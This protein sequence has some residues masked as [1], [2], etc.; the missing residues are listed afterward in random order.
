MTERNGDWVR[1]TVSLI[2]NVV[3]VIIAVAV[4]YGKLVGLQEQYVNRAEA[5]D[6]FISRNELTAQLEAINAKQSAMQKQL[7]RIEQKL[8]SRR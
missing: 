8:D 5:Y 7:D 2:I 6:K 4:A 1:W 3:F